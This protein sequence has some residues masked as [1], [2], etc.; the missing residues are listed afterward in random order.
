M[1]TRPG[2]GQARRGLGKGWGMRGR[3]TMGI[4]VLALL[5]AANGWSLWYR[6]AAITETYRQLSASRD[7]LANVLSATNRDT[8]TSHALYAYVRKGK[9]VYRLAYNQIGPRL[10]ASDLK[11]LESGGYGDSAGVQQI[12]LAST[13]LGAVET[14]AMALMDQSKPA[15]A[16]AL[17]DDEAYRSWQ[18]YFTNAVRQFSAQQQDLAASL[19]RQLQTQWQALLLWQGG[20]MLVTLLVCGALGVVMTRLVVGP[21]VRLERAALALSRGNLETRVEVTSR[22]ELGRLAVA[23]NKMAVVLNEQA[24]SSTARLEKITKDLGDS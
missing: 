22:D 20:I 24:M 10:S 16:L 15:E 9:P 14:Q 12:R 23:F 1:T 13:R 17:L 3:A 11:A 4:L 8:D 19:R 21:I 6:S 5:M 18:N 2:L 7:A